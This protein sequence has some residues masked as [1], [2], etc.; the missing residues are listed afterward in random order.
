MWNQ[1]RGNSFEI[2]METAESKK[3][4]WFEG[5]EPL[6]ITAVKQVS[7]YNL[8]EREISNEKLAV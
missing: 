8:P 7:K 3:S 4:H 5:A 1:E 6:W 2:K